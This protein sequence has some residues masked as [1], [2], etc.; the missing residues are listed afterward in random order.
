MMGMVVMTAYGDSD[1][2]LVRGVMM[3]GVCG[4]DDDDEDDDWCGPDDDG[5]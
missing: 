4:G 3:F 1:R 2:R 5:C